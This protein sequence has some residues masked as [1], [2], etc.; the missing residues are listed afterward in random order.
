M[1]LGRRH[2]DAHRRMLE[3]VLDLSA[4][5]ISERIQATQNAL[6][7]GSDRIYQPVLVT[8]APF[9]SGL[10]LLGIPDFLLREQDGY[11]VRDCKISR[12]ITEKDH[13]EILEQLD[14]Y[15]WLLE[16]NTG[17]APVR[18]EVLAGDG[19]MH[20]VPYQKGSHAFDT[21]L[22]VENVLRNGLST[23]EPVGW[24]KCQGCA[25]RGHCWIEAAERRDPSVLPDVDQ[26]MA[27]VLREM[28][29][30][31]F[32]QLPERFDAGTLAELKKP[33]GNQMV[34]IGPKAAVS[35]LRHAE[36][37]TNNRPVRLAPPAIPQS[38]NC[39]MFD[40]EG[41][42]PQMDEL[43]KIYLWG[44][45]VFG[46]RPGECRQAVADFGADG[47]R[48][49]WTRFLDLAAAVFRDYGDIPFVHWATYERT[50]VTK[51]VERYGDRDGI[52]ARVLANLCDL[53]K[54]TRD[55]YVL[56]TYSYSIKQIEGLA[57]YKRRLE[58][59]GGSWSIAQYIKAVETEDE[60]LRRDTM[61]K[62]LVYNREDLEATWAVLGW[63]KGIQA[64]G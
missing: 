49:G 41:L 40:L 13:P 26:G 36:A 24:A 18:Q 61:D 7:E 37:L 50:N 19:T 63:L 42:P 57:G 56:P 32:R 6:R 25:Y 11:V 1:L 9:A 14:F 51:Y 46:A 29:I 34:R 39:V 16:A 38:D 44:L 33:R 17:R 20:A 31:D 53:L 64:E 58:E 45:Q 52:A 10:E 30:H 55:A 43:Q 2:E 47:D 27:V 48:N 3:P 5:S 21:L 4:G 8:E 62:I 22:R 23:Y 60:Q 54:V 12:R 59:S 28:G 35:I 15:G